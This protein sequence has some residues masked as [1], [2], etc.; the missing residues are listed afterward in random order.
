MVRLNN[1]L[2]RIQVSRCPLGTCDRGL[3][4]TAEV[5]PV[6]FVTSWYRVFLYKTRN[7]IYSRWKRPSWL[8]TIAK[9]RH[10][11]VCTGIVGVIIS[12][13]F[14][15][16]KKSNTFSSFLLDG[17]FWFKLLL[18]LIVENLC[19][20]RPERFRTIVLYNFVYGWLRSLHQILSLQFLKLWLVNVKLVES[21]VFTLLLLYENVFFW[22]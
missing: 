12:L 4:H 3:L 2:F 19:R 10:H 17:L 15:L 11:L 9:D 20:E 6:A 14:T 18:S 7:C 16:R 8:L 1:S 22:L 5:F 13:L 21:W